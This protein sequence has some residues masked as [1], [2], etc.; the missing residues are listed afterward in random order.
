MNP[1]LIKTAFRITL[2]ILITTSIVKNFPLYP[3]L[4]AGNLV[5]VNYQPTDEDFANP[6]RGFMKQSSIWPNKDFNPSQVDRLEPSDS[7]VWIYFRLDDYRD[8]RDGVGVTLSDYQGK[9]LESL[10]S[11]RGLD[12]IQQT[13]ST[14]RNKGLKLIIRFIYNW[15]PGSTSNPNDATPDVPLNLAL[16]HI[17]QVKPLLTANADV[18]VAV[19]AGFVGHWGEWHSSKYL[20]TLESKQA[21]LNALLNALPSDR[22]LQIR[23]PRYIEIFY[24]GPLTSSTAFQGTAAS[25]MGHHNDCFLADDTDEGTY[26]S[27]SGGPTPQPTSHYCDNALD[28]VQCWKDYVAQQGLYTP[29]GGESCHANPP[30]SECPTDSQ[31]PNALQELAYLHWSVINNDFSKDVLDSWVTGGCMP[32]IRRR[33]GY[34]FAL[35]NLVVSDQAPPGGTLPFKLTLANQGFAA[36]FN[37]RPAIL[38]LKEKTTGYQ[39]EIP[40]SNVDPRRWTPGQTTT[41]DTQVPLPPNL[42]EGTYNLYLWLPDAYSTLRSRPEYA[43]HLANQNVWQPTTGYN[44]LFDHLQISGTPVATPTPYPVSR[45]QLLALYDQLPPFSEPFIDGLI[46]LLDVVKTYLSN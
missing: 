14:A 40:L 16:Q 38:V 39:T 25:R 45:Q 27:K 10:G 33:L 46:N 11:G 42:P 17:A 23:Y 1:K 12:V 41:I 28:V 31:N 9:L 3:V 37:P 22:M 26:N 35:S 29:I 4:A 32:E 8:P 36:P 20:Y 2:M 5:T 13:F 34:R 7:V 19:Q 18:I 24:Q 6:E 15:G 30:R 21:I 44:L 43:I